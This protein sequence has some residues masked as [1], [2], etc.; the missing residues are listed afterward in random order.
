MGVGCV[1]GGQKVK[2]QTTHTKSYSA[3]I[4]TDLII[5]SLF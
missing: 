5:I 3:F 1:G 2:L 4:F